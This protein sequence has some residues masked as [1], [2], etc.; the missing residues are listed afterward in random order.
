MNPEQLCTTMNPESRTSGFGSMMRSRLS[1]L[2]ILMG[3]AVEPRR[4]FRRKRP[5][6]QKPRH[7]WSCHESL[8]CGATV[9]LD[10]TN[11]TIAM[12]EAPNRS[13]NIMTM[14]LLSDYA[15]SVIIGR[16]LPDARRPAGAPARPVRDERA[17][18]H[19]RRHKKPRSLAMS[20]AS[21][22]R[23]AIARIRHDGALPV[24][25]P[26]YP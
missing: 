15:M 2:T 19:A 13:A 22:I 12:N 4:K 3:D 24:L 26:R 10:P 5:E 8:H 11:K 16:A 7:S 1:N 14:H 18:E 23:M 9:S 21:T 17:G 20:S 25:S 6:R